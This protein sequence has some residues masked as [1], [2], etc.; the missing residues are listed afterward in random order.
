MTL[1]VI[2][3]FADIFMKYGWPG[4]IAI[5]ALLALYF[6][7]TYINKKNT[8][9]TTDTINDGFKTLATEMSKSISEQNKVLLTAFI[10][11]SE[12][13]TKM[14]KDIMTDVMNNKSRI[15]DEEHN[16]SNNTRLNV[17]EHISQKMF[18]LLK[19]Y[20]CD[21]VFILEFHNSKQNFSGLSF[22]W[23]DMTYEKFAKGLHTIS[24]SFKDQE[25]S[26]LIPII[27]D[28][29]NG[30]GLMHYTI[31]ELD[32][33]QERSPILYDRLRQ[34][35]HVQEC[36]MLGLYSNDNTMIGMVVLEYERTFLPIEV[37]NVKDLLSEAA[38]ISSL[39]DLNKNTND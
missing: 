4:I 15:D 25:I 12:G 2:T 29:N 1:A 8:K 26:S 23:Y 39:L 20:N 11:Q 16:K 10:N 6:M 28:V 31:D 35:R 22:V 7:F 32:E 33:L 9:Q 36:I 18:S 27:N 21:R 34:E 3:T 24:N 13:N 19:T 17:S 30:C 38:T 37:Y 14:I 5:I